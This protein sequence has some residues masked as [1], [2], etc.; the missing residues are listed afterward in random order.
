MCLLAVELGAGGILVVRWLREPMPPQPDLAYLHPDTQAELLRFRERVVVA[1]TASR[2]RKLGQAYLLF[3]LLRESEYCCRIAA[4]MN[5]ADFRTQY[6]WALALHQQGKTDE[7]I[8]RFERAAELT[9]PDDDGRYDESKCRYAVGRNLLRQEQTSAAEAAFREAGDFPPAQHQL[10]RILVRSQRY[11]EAVALLDAL[12]VR[13]PVAAKFYQLRA[14]AREGLGDLPGAAADRLRVERSITFLPSDFL[15]QEL[16][17]EMQRFGLSRELQQCEKQIQDRQFEAAAKTLRPLLAAGWRQH[18]AALL[19]DCEY[20]LGRNDVAI[21][22]MDRLMDRE[23]ISPR[24]LNFKAQALLASGREHEAVE[25]WKRS[26]RLQTTEEAHR[27]L[28]EYFA[29]TKDA[30]ALKHHRS[31]A[32]FAR[33]VSAYRADRAADAVSDLKQAV[34]LDPQFA[35]GWYYLAAGQ[36]AAGRPKSATAALRNCLKA[37]PDDGRALRMM[38]MVRSGGE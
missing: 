15:I 33:G 10:A 19:A 29:K 27:R 36:L 4:E 7:A 11:G 1:P 8:E 12:I 37:N 17:N 9:T 38:V 25:N 16:H 32:L 30:A 34:A 28:A 31:R 2:W 35:R 22:L 13:F 20:R 21:E 6:L 5:P 24:F 14:E 23:G 3:G 18:A 26:A